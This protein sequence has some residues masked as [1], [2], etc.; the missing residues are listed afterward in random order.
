MVLP[1]DPLQFA[2]VRED[3]RVEESLLRERSAE[4]AL[5]IASGGCTA[6]H[7][8]ARLPELRLTLVEPNPAQVQHVERKLAALR[9]NTRSEFNIDDDRTDGLHE[10]GNFE[11]LFRLL[12]AVLDL[13]VVSAAERRV[14]LADAA[15]DWR[16][17]IE[18]PYWPV[19]FSTAFADDLL[20]T[21]FGPDA[22]QHAEPG[23][24][25]GYF[26]RRIEAGLVAADRDRNPWLHHV[27]LGHYLPAAV[28]WPPFLQEPPRDLEPFEVL[29]VT[30]LEVDSFAP[31]DFVQLSNVL[32]WMSE[33]DCRALAGRLGTELRPG[34]R[35]LWRQ[36]N[37]PRDLVGHFESAFKFSE[38]RDGQ[39]TESERSLFYDA[40]HLGTRR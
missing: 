28:T 35:V 17:V 25:P 14:R 34:S 12:R 10:C 13:W 4:R 15:A 24:Y 20:V 8:R 33:T 16:D 22:V 26:R 27:L 19:A 38:I 29:P 9:Q 37:D 11:R 36:L 21:M 31:Y 39:L 40:V 6:L 2:V 3:P 5:L 23:S 1:R 30:L 32:D 18:H 7:L